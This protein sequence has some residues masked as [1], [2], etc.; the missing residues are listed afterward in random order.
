VLATAAGVLTAA[1]AVRAVTGDLDRGLYPPGSSFAEAA[2]ALAAAGGGPGVTIVAAEREVGGNLRAC[3]PRARCLCRERPLFVPPAD[4]PARVC[5]VVWNTV[6]GDRPPWGTA[7]YVERVLHARLP[8]A[9]AVRT[10]TVRPPQ[11]GRQ[12]PEL[13]YV[14]VPL[15][16]EMAAGPP[17]P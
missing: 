17:R 9:A 11:P 1:Q 14:V 2:G 5:V 15:A 6:L 7:E 10:T 16:A 4:H 3:L 12:A 8:A 13:R